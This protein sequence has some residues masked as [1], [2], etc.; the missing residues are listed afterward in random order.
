MFIK[1]VECLVLPGAPKFFNESEW[2]SSFFAQHK[3]KINRVHFL[4]DL[5]LISMKCY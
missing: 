4:R 5:C 1:E 3:A 2:G